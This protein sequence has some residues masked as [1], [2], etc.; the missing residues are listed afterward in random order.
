MKKSLIFAFSFIGQIGFTVAVPL[1]LL[2]LLGRYLDG[3]FAPGH[4]YFF[5]LGLVLAAILAYFALKQVVKR[6]LKEF[7]RINS[8]VT[9]TKKQ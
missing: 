2:A 7:N 8:E 5:F 1:V 9:N 6:A 4:H 3:K